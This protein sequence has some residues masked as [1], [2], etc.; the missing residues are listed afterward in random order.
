MDYFGL[1][2]PYAYPVRTNA[3]DWTPAAVQLNRTL[4]MLWE[5][6][7]YWTRLTVNSIVGRYPEQQAATAR[8]LRNPT[9][10]GASLEP[11]YGKAIADRFAA[12]LR[13]HLT[14]AAEFVTDL[15]DGKQAEAADAQK[16]W[17]ANAADI[18]EFLGRI[19]PYWSR[20]EWVLMMNE[21]LRLLTLEAAYRLSADYAAN[22]AISDPIERQ[23]LE[24]ADVMT[25][26][27]IRQFPSSF[28]IV[29]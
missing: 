15:R 24:M 1:P 5:Q 29:S 17:Y 21:H 9:D 6:H 20:E 26:G 28:G 2:Y 25:Q 4:R 27:I 3:G 16:R 19:N 22:A 13:D 14:I 12:L 18:A 10:F 23:A 7:V 8:L 11:Y